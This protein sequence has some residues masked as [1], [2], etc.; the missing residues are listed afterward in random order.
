MARRISMATR[1]ELLEAVG[2]RYRDAARAE[3]SL[4]LDEFAAVTCYHRKH[5]I[6]LLAGGGGREEDAQVGGAAASKTSRWTVYGV[7]VQD[8]LIELWEVADRVWSKRLRPMASIL[9]PALERHGRV[10]LDEATRA[11]LLTVSA[12]S[13][14]RL[15]MDWCRAQGLEVTRSRAYRKND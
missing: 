4:I 12:A 5:A 13:I 2:A 11:R 8:A 1:A 15:V 3:R 6:R 7:E 9:L 14:D 10:M